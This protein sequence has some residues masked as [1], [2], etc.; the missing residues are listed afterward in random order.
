MF[1]AKKRKIIKTSLI[2]GSGVLLTGA[3]FGITFGVINQHGKTYQYPLSDMTK[4]NLTKVTIKLIP[5]QVSGTDANTESAKKDDSDKSQVKTTLS[6]TDSKNNKVVKT[7]VLLTNSND[8][9]Q[10]QIQNLIP[11]GYNFDPSK[12]A[13]E[14]T[15]T[16]QIGQNNVIYIVPEIK[17][18]TKT[19]FVFYTQGENGAQENIKTVEKNN[20][21]IS[22]ESNFD[23]SKLLPEGYGFVSSQIPTFIIGYTNRFNVKKL[24]VDVTFNLKFMSDNKQIGQLVSVKAHKGDVVN[25]LRYIPEGYKLAENVPETIT[26]DNNTFEIKVVEIPRQIVT[27]LNFVEVQNGSDVIVES[28]KITTDQFAKIDYTKYL[29]KNYQLAPGQ[30]NIS[31]ILGQVNTI[32][33]TKIK[34]IITTTIRFIDSKDGTSIGEP[35]S[36]QTYDDENITFDNSWIPKGYKLVQNEIKIIPGQLNNISIEKIVN[37][38]TAIVEY[39]WNGRIV[40]TAKIEGEEGTDVDL[41][42]SS[43]MPQGFELP[44]NDKQTVVV[45][46]A[47]QTFVINV[48][49]KT[50]ETTFKFVSNNVQIGKIATIIT[51]P[52]VT[53]IS[54]DE[55]KKYV[56]EGYQI[57]QK[58]TYAFKL[59][60]ENVIEVSKILKEIT[61]TITFKD[62]GNTIGSPH[63][64]KTLEGDTKPIDW[65]QYLPKGYHVTAEPIII[66]GKD[67]DIQI[68]KDK[69]EYSYTLIFKDGNKLIGEVS[70]KYFDD[71][72]PKVTDFVPSG[73]K[74]VNSLDASQMPQNS[75]KTYQVTPIIPPKPPVVTKPDLTPEEKKQ[76][77]EL[78]NSRQGQTV[79][80]NNLQIPTKEEDLPEVPKGKVPKEV[81][82]DSYKRLNQYKDLLRS[83]KDLTADDLKDIYR[84]V[85]EKNPDLLEVFAKYLNGQIQMPGRPLIPK[86]QI[87]Q[88][89]RAQLEAASR[90]MQSEIAAGRVPVFEVT[91]NT[92]GYDVTIKFDYMDDKY[93]PSIQRM[94]QDNQSRVLSNGGKYNRQPS[95]I[96]N[97]DYIGWKKF[98]VSGTV[99]GITPEK[100]RNKVSYDPKTGK[101]IKGDDGLR[102][103]EYIPDGKDDFSKNKAPQRMLTVD[104]SNK[105]GYDKFLQ[106]LKENP[107]ITMVRVDKIGYGDKN[108]SLRQLLSQLPNSVK[109]VNLFFYT[110]DTTAIAGLEN[111]HLDEVGIYTTM[112][113]LDKRNDKEDWGIDPVGLKNTKFASFEGGTI[114]SWEA[115]APGQ[116]A[117]SIIFNTIRPSKHANFQDI[118]DGFNIALK[119]KANWKIFNG[120]FGVGGYPTG[121]DLSLNHNIKSMK[122]LPLNQRVFRKL[123]LHADGDTF[124]LPIGEIVSGQFGSLVVQ[125]PDRAKMYFDNPATHILHLT[126]K[127]S[128][129]GQ[130]YGIHLYGLLE[131][132]KQSLDTIVVDNLEAEQLIKSSQ[133]W[134]AFGSS[135]KLIVKNK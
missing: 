77:Q 35:L 55:V 120:T 118:K 105:S 6:F 100:D 79:D 2:L 51:A 122:D 34:K 107:S 47:S 83:N 129:I 38:V 68:A 54:L 5:S 114:E 121:I 66:K 19:T 115:L 131:A 98:D 40:S 65:K 96:L 52:D 46:L 33:V 93:N 106:I 18:Q 56:P 125:G 70:G 9:L 89:A 59:G 78:V 81:A 42:S 99:K 3:I 80:V 69:I 48:I 74:L 41:S 45:K 123:T 53:S 27:T 57:V 113:N 1:K 128:D 43:Y 13:D 17:S 135:Y 87:R 37:N 44:K 73:Y 30:N 112:P 132:G 130:N 50:I 28:Q 61:T 111:V 76:V 20:D 95:G 116:R 8:E 58:A 26:A 90:I 14:T 97:G 84:E 67:N 29:P 23:L 101:Q 117:A 108:E 25:I 32:K 24:E 21:E 49:K 119:T 85:W 126:G 16:A 133:A 60:Q 127:A 62:N 103:Y 15:I 72:I 124:S 104:A 88:I 75:S 36:I 22:S 64:F 12:Y 91:G 10:M 86:D 63:T 94:I 134:G 109:V 110:K 82:T 4:Q 71:S 31:I 7:V 92:F 11:N 102:V 39:K